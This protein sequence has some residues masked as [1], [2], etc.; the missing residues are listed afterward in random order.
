VTLVR[1]L[2]PAALLDVCDRGAAA[3]TAERALLLLGAALPGARRGELA[4]LPLA[5]RDRL[6]LELRAASTG[7]E[8][9]AYVECPGCGERL[10]LAL[11]AEALHPAEPPEPGA[12]WEA[13]GGGVRMRFR[14]PDSRDLAAA[15]GC[16]SVA[17]ARRV[18]GARC[19]T[20]ATDAAGAPVPVLP[21]EALAALAARMDQVAPTTDVSLALQCPSCGRGWDAPLDVA[22]FV[23]TE[24]WARARRLLR[25]VHA[26]ARAYHWSEAEILALPAARRRAYLEMAE[27]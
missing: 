10:E 8:L 21:D 3:G 22:A 11:D 12:E 9:A 20:S 2:P 17:E 18:L 19:V 25:E 5:E 26:L 13:E 24:T 23:W 6:L 14:L 1:A 27:G 15:A 4:A 7:R 16:A